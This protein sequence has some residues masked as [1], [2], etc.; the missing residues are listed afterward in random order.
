MTASDASSLAVQPGTMLAGKYRVERIL[1]QGGMGV[2]V[3]AHHLSLDEKVAIKLLL[4]GALRNENVVA[5]FEREARAAF[6]IKSE[7]VAR[8]IDV[9]EL[10]TG[11]PYMV[12]EYLEGQDLSTLL[13][14]RGAIPVDL[15]S[16]YILQACEAL[17]EAHSLGIVHRDLKP[18]NLFLARRPSGAPAIKVLD[19]GISKSTLSTEH[20]ALTKT[21]AV[22]GS[23]LYMSPEQMQ[24]SKN[25]DARSDIWSIGIVLY[26]LVTGQ[27]PFQ[28]DT[29]PELVLAVVNREPPA[30]ESMQGGV[31]AGFAAVVARCLAKDPAARYASVA[32]L[33]RDLAAFAPAEGRASLDR[34]G[35]V[36]RG[37]GSHVILVPDPS[38][39]RAL[40]EASTLLGEPGGTT[41]AEAV[42][43]EKSAPL[44][45]RRA[46]GLIAIG[47]LSATVLG[48]A[49]FRAS[50]PPPVVAAPPI[51]PLT[52]ELAAPSPLPSSATPLSSA[53]SAVP[54][55]AEAPSAAAPA[56]SSAHVHRPPALPPHV[57]P[58]A[59]AKVNCDP[60]YTLDADGHRQY[61]VECLGNPH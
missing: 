53:P 43:S 5:R 52:T 54:T 27:A 15:A 17:A 6:K 4:P 50:P 2:V 30:L 31:P 13:A 47:L 35:H 40:P 56:H 25:V 42:S 59:A 18:A 9:G 28:A 39:A 60:P 10:D 44:V 32:E 41:T 33:A 37:S 46:P 12:M 55:P 23:P 21:T 36:L 19:F 34:I 48:V 49:L 57:T 29:L 20:A 16:L 58:S 61:K 8:V 45:S 22:M 1:G 14:D 26:E 38:G 51:A 24:S 3:Q 11:A 7:H